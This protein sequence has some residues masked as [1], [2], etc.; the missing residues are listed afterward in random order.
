MLAAP[1]RIDFA[2][3]TETLDAL[4]RALRDAPSPVIDLST[5]KSFDSAALAVF[6]ELRRRQA[7][8]PIDLRQP[9][10]PL[11]ALAQVYGIAELLFETPAVAAGE[12][13]AS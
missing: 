9:P 6:L 12:S 10:P 11:L 7:G 3:A 13:A 4:Q 5:L 1:E 8:S 2:T